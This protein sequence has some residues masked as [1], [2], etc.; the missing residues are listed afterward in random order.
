MAQCSEKDGH[1]IYLVD[2]LFI[3]CRFPERI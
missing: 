3:E 1:F 2:I